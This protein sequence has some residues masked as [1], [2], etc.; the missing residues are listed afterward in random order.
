MLPGGA[1]LDLKSSRP[2]ALL[3]WNPAALLLGQW[4]CVLV[5]G[6]APD[7]AVLAA[8]AAGS[9]V[10]IAGAHAFVSRRELLYPRLPA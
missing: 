5:E 9:L 8:I 6:R 2:G 4:R 3:A 10:A 1:R 7:A